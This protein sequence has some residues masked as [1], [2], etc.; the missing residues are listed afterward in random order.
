[1]SAPSTPAVPFPDAHLLAA[2][3]ALLDHI[4]TYDVP[5]PTEIHMPGAYGDDNPDSLLVIADTHTYPAWLESLVVD[6]EDNETRRHASGTRYVRTL[7]RCRLQTG[8]RVTVLACRPVPLEVLDGGA[9][10]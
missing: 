3:R 9:S 1:M 10:A 7:F 2:T 8:V 4:E 6:H 5:M